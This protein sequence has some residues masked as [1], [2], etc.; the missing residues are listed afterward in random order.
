LLLDEGADVH[1]RDSQGNT[2]L[3]LTVGIPKGSLEIV[4]LLLARKTDI[5]TQNKEGRSALMIA[6]DRGR[7]DV[8]Q[9]L[10]ESGARLDLEDSKKSTALDHA[11]TSGYAHI[12][13]L[14]FAKGAGSKGGYTTEASVLAATTNF[15]L[16][17][18]AVSGNLNEVKMQLTAGADVNMRSENGYTALLLAVEFDYSDGTVV[19][20]LLERGADPNLPNRNGE[21]P[22]MIAARRNNR[23]AITALLAHKASV[24]LRNQH[25]QTALHVAAGELHARIVSAL[26]TARAEVDARDEQGRTPL[27]LAADNEDRVPDDVMEWLLAKGAEVNATDNDGNT[28]LMLSAK[29]GSMS[30]VE[31]LLTHKAN[32]NLKNRSGTTAIQF[33]RS[34]SENKKIFNANLV[35]ERIVASLL[36][37]GARE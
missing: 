7:I 16:Q 33:A 32:V 1:S 12:A 26:L 30:A 10:L 14:L 21:T 19:T 4:R 29:S 11:V 5:N 9:L 17:R 27:L 23:N 34:L 3:M 2:A 25:G 8:V 28:P 35:E 6:S 15:A 13:K 20:Y 37:A 31:L 24:D 22:L 18:A 36:K